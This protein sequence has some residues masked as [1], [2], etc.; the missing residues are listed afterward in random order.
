MEIVPG[1]EP[2]YF[3]PGR[4]LEGL[5]TVS[6]DQIGTLFLSIGDEIKQLSASLKEVLGKDSETD[7]Q[8]TL[9]EPL[10]ADGRAQRPS[11]SRTRAGSSET[12]QNV[13]KAVEDVE[14]APR[15]GLR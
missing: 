14:P 6:F 15:R 10:V 4:V 11:S 7:L 5:P 8:Q 3:G 12:V 1:G 13:S 9:R 2:E